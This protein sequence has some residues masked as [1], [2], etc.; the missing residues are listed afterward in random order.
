MHTQLNR[1]ITLLDAEAE[2]YQ[3]L[4]ACIQSEKQAIVD[5]DFDKLGDIGRQ[6]EAMILRQREL[7]QKR[8]Q[9]FVQLSAGMAMPSSE[10][11]LAQL[12][13]QAPSP[14]DDQLLRCRSR[15]RELLA[16]LGAENDSVQQLVN[17]G[18]A[19]V[20]G[21]YHLIS[22]LLDANPVYHCSGNLQPANATGR[23]HQSDY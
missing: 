19:L 2:F 11:T 3:N 23:F 20:R 18:L 5:L 10:M 9:A 22:Q 21:S 4:L 1:L 16:S 14:Y 17:H 6:K 8:D 7:A 13:R 12:S 15:L